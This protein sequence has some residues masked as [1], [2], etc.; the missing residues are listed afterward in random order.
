MC[1]GRQIIYRRYKRVGRQQQQQY[2]DISGSVS[3]LMS[4]SYAAAYQLTDAELSADRP[5]VGASNELDD[6]VRQSHSIIAVSWELSRRPPTSP[7]R[8]SAPRYHAF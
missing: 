5:T 8:R 3:V 1:R 2:R 7:R 6:K 4:H